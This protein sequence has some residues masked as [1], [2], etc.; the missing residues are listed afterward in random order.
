MWPRP[1]RPH[2]HLRADLRADGTHGPGFL[3]G[4]DA[5]G[6]LHRAADRFR[7][8]RDERPRIDD[9]DR[10]ACVVPL[11]HLEIVGPRVYRRDMD[12]LSGRSVEGRK[13]VT[14]LFCDL[15]AYTELAERL[16]FL[17]DAVLGQV[18]TVDGGM[19]M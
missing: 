9:L 6:L 7:V 19:V 17:G 14:V 3:D 5:A 16:E 8:H 18:I 13:T 12:A 2:R 10:V 15:V 4:D 1:H 11:E